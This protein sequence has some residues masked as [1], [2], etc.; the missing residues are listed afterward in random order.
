MSP[1]VIVP[2]LVDL[3]TISIILVKQSS[4]VTD[5]AVNRPLKEVPI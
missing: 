1:T 3:R 5:Y 4:L 2:S